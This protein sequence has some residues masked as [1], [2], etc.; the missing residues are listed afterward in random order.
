MAEIFD[1]FGAWSKIN[2]RKDR[3]KENEEKNS[4]DTRIRYKRHYIND[5]HC[6]PIFLLDFFLF[7]DSI[8]RVLDFFSFSKSKEQS[9]CE[10][11]IHPDI[12]I[13][14]IRF[15]GSYIK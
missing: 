11:G 10:K 8:P 14:I 1:R 9:N 4:F 13:K 3:R 7:T 15:I 2:E 6:Y 5:F 12:I